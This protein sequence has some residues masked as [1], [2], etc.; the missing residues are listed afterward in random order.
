MKSESKKRRN[1]IIILALSLA[2][3]MIAIVAVGLIMVFNGGGA[4]GDH[5]TLANKAYN[6]KDYESAIKYYWLAIEESEDPSADAYMLLGQSY[7]A[8]GNLSDASLAYEVGYEATGS[9]TLH[10]F[11]RQTYFTIHH[12]YPVE[13]S[14]GDDEENNG[15]E[16]KTVP[17]ETSA[18]NMNTAILSSFG[19][20]SY[21]E[22][23]K[24]YGTASAQ[25]LSSGGYAVRCQNLDA[26][27]YYVTEDVVDNSVLKPRVNKRPNYV[28]LD[29]LATLFV[30]AGETITYSQIEAMKLRNVEKKYDEDLG[31]NVI[32]I[33]YENCV[34]TIN[35]DEN[36]DFRTDAINRIDITGEQLNISVYKVEGY[37]VDA[38]TGNPI[39]EA[40]VILTNNSDSSEKEAYTDG[41]G[42][43]LIEE[44]AQ[45]EYVLTTEKDGYIESKTEVSVDGYEEIISL[46][47]SLSSV[48]GEGQIRI[49]LSWGVSPADLDSYLIGTAS[50]GTD[51]F[52]YYIDRETRGR[53]G[54]VIVELDRDDTD[55]EGP[56]TTTIYD[57]NG[58]YEFIVNR[59]SGYG[60]ISGSEAVVTIYVGSEVYEVITLPEEF[61]DAIWSV[62]RIENG[63]IIIT[64]ES[65]DSRF[66]RTSGLK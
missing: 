16:K 21:E 39:P 60:S 33:T 8:I 9:E 30:G 34:I 32:V 2:V 27:L 58:S 11:Y 25:S 64:N 5:L 29:S 26:T 38:A 18:L 28:R 14:L 49:V 3:V 62:F 48:L 10:T 46:R 45:G 43:F 59:Y 51:V 42:Y 65:A 19:N 50:D 37:L 6:S 52:N 22:Y 41:E 63:Q 17:S 23:E 66:D 12:E 56:E 53:S 44:V 47:I 57:P 1:S 61:I 7:E 15:A 40:R 36:G 54:D 13:K 55:G 31:S 24:T 35:T 4:K 20:F